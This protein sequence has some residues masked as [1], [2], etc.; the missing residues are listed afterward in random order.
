MRS[1]KRAKNIAA[2]A[3]AAQILDALGVPQAQRRAALV[4]AKAITAA[5]PLASRSK[6]RAPTPPARAGRSA[7][8]ARSRST[9]AKRVRPR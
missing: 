2:P 3:T 5:R 4:L 8:A 1:L 7:V 9:K 6:E